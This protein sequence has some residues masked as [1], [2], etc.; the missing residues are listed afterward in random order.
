MWSN[1][2]NVKSLAQYGYRERLFIFHLIS[3]ITV[4]F[5]DNVLKN[6]EVE[7]TINL[8]SSVLTID[9]MLSKGVAGST[10]VAL[11]YY[12]ST[13]YKVVDRLGEAL[14]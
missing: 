12:R 8:D 10:V 14:S 7:I 2:E 4:F 5:V 1:I 6:T 3:F 13:Q 11:F 9:F